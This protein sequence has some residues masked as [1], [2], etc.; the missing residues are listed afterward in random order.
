EKI[1]LYIG[2]AF[3][4]VGEHKRINF[5]R[6]SHTEVEETFEIILRNHKDSSVLVTVVEHLTGDWKILNSSHQYVK[7]DASTVEIP[8]EVAKDSEAKITYTV[9]TKW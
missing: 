3:D 4:V 6:I 9:R 8:V 7:K 1:R 2:D 5:R